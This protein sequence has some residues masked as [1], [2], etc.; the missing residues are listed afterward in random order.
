MATS[1]TAETNRTLT[2]VEIICSLHDRLVEAD[3][4]RLAKPFVVVNLWLAVLDHRRSRRRPR[5]AVVGSG[6]AGCLPRHEL[7]GHLHDDQVRARS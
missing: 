3:H 4:R 7:N 1:T 5:H 2:S 6:V